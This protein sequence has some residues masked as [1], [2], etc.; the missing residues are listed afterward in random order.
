MSAGVLHEVTDRSGAWR[1]IIEGSMVCLLIED[2]H[3]KR[4]MHTFSADCA[5]R[6]AAGLHKAAKY[7][8]T[9]HVLRAGEHVGRI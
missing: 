3:G 8:Q 4:Y 9:R 2:K 5:D 1:V 6:I 7:L